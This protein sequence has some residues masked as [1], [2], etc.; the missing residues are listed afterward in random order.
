MEPLGRFSEVSKEGVLVAAAE[1]SV[2]LKVV[3]P[4]NK[5]KISASDWANGYQVKVGEHLI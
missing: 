2:L 4:P 3:Q 1:G 5:P